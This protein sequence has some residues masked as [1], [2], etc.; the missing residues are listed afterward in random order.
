VKATNTKGLFN[1]AATVWTDRLG[2]QSPQWRTLYKPP[3]KK[4]TGDLQWRILHGAIA[5]NAFLSVFNSSVVNECPFFSL[6]ETIFHVFTECRR[7]TE[8]FSVLTGVFNLFNVVFSASVFIGG[9]TYSKTRKAK[10]QLLNFLL[11]E[12]KLAVYL[13]RRDK[14]QDGPTCD[15]VALWRQSVKARLRL[16]FCFHKAT[17]NMDVFKEQWG[18]DRA[19]CR[20]SEQGELTFSSH[21]N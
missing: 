19:L 10:C 2:G 9:V 14:L 15:V 3:L 18:C 11:G 4:R 16:E 13:T 20:V 17:E 12:A 7:L 1:R 21:L 6:S 8:L 5:T